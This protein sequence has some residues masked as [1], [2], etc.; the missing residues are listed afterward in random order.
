MRY[1]ALNDLRVIDLTHF[2][3]GPYATKLLADMGADVIKVEPPWGEGGR[4]LG[5]NRNGDAHDE[6]SDRGG[7]F[8][9]LNLN[10]R[11]ITLNLKHDRG[12]ELLARLLGG[13]DLLVENFAP[14]TLASFGL[15]PEEL[16]AKFPKLSVISISNFGQD[17]PERGGALNDLVLFARGG[18]TFPV[19]ER[20]R[21]PLTP[22]GSLAQ[23]VGA[24]YGAIGALQAIAA[25]DAGLGRGQHVDISLLEAT[26]AT[27]I[28]E[29]VSFQY[30]GIVRGREGKRFAVGPFMIVTLKCKDGYAGLHCVT[31]KQFEGLCDL[32]GRSEL[33]ADSRFRTAL[34]R[35]TNNDALL[36]IVEEF[37][38]DR[39]R[40][41]LY[42]EGRRRAIPLV[43]IPSVAEVMDWEQTRARNY[44]E[45]ID[46][47]VLGKIRVPGTPL[48]LTSHRA[49]NSRPAPRLGEHNQEIL[50]ANLGLSRAEID[51]LKQSG[52]I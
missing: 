12:R 51:A 32:M 44:F 31:D 45:T 27:M 36:K 20:D 42:G 47:P 16:I 46:D 10:K 35:Y 49:E 30:S 39:D 48:R 9:F 4:K 19:G 23:Y 2:I 13:A 18:W 43:P 17:G 26:V 25:R 40:K 29:T 8:A 15:A 6:L 50:A 5:P 11:A 21:A 3:A 1:S 38:I 33:L 24:V 52:T 41:W 22:P 7:L 34:D 28:Y 14:G 37:F